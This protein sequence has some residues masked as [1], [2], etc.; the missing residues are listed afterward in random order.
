[1]QKSTKNSGAVIFQ[2][3]NIDSKIF[4]R[5]QKGFFQ[6]IRRSLGWILTILFMIIP[7]IQYQGEQAILF[8][9]EVQ[10]LNIFSMVLYPQDLFIFVL[11]LMFSAFALFFVSNKGW[12]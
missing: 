3:S 12:Q 11:L 4:V 5:E 2:T 7:F 1:M 8:D 10:K 6:R 9:L